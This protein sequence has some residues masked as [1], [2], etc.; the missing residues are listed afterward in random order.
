MWSK[1]NLKIF[2]SLGD[3]TNFL[4]LLNFHQNMTKIT[5]CILHCMYKFLY[6]CYS[7]TRFN[8]ITLVHGKSG[9]INRMIR[10]TDYFYLVPASNGT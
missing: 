10:I 8:E 9:N 1:P 6:H 4:K 3:F 2:L 7:R 5:P